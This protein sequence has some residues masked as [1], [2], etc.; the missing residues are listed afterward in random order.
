MLSPFK[1]QGLTSVARRFSFRLV[2]DSFKILYVYVLINSSLSTLNS[3]VF[4]GNIE[5]DKSKLVKEKSFFE[6]NP[7]TVFAYLP[8]FAIA[9]AVSRS[10]GFPSLSFRNQYWRISGP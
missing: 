7:T 6:P 9:S 3:F 1:Y 8:A 5:F 2:N 4:N 10:T